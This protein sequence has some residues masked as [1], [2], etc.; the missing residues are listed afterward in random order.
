VRLWPLFYLAVSWALA[1][2]LGDDSNWMADRLL[3]RG[4]MSG[5]RHEV[6]N[7]MILNTKSKVRCLIAEF[8]LVGRG[9][10]HRLPGFSSLGRLGV[11]P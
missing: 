6:V 8:Y 4:D 2:G 5:L 10:R 3:S 9:L 1:W 11:L 7:S